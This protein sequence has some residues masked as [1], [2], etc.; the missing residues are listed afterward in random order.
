MKTFHL[1]NLNGEKIKNTSYEVEEQKLLST[2]AKDGDRILQMGGNIGTSCIAASLS[3]NLR[4]NICVEP[5]TRILPLLRKNTKDFN[6]E[7][8]EGI[9]ADK[10]DNLRLHGV[11][12]DTSK[13]DWGASIGNDKTGQ[14]VQCTSLGDLTPEDGFSMVF[15]DCEGCFPDFIQNYQ[16]DLKKQP[17]HT[18]I[19]EK[20][21]NVDYSKVFSFMSN[22]GYTCT[23]DFHTVCKRR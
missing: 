17:I 7:V 2:H 8:V 4:R 23:G 13:N 1:E 10:C 16:E 3:A 14:P 19:F 15:A 22:E 12:E 18:Y 9:V 5:S 11:G 21:G 6:V 20:D